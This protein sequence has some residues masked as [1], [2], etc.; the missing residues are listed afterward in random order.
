[1]LAVMAK[2]KNSSLHDLIWVTCVIFAIV[3]GSLIGLRGNVVDQH[4]SYKFPKF[5]IPHEQVRV[6]ILVYHYVEYVK[7]QKDTIRKSLS[8]APHV[9]EDQIKTLIADGY[10]FITFK[11]LNQY[12]DGRE[13]LPPKSII[14][15]F[16]DGYEDFYTDVFPILKKYKVPA[17]QYVISG[18]IDQPNYMKDR[19]L[20]EVIESGLVEIGA[21]TVDHRNLKHLSDL[22]AEWEISQSKKDLQEKYHILVDAFAYPYGGYNDHTP[23][24]VRKAGFS[25][26]VTT[27]G[28]FMLSNDSRFTLYRIHPGISIGY[29]LLSKF[30]SL[31]NGYNKQ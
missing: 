28:G 13:K 25:T 17:V 21:H 15:T 18:F 11:K 24:F 5:L 1:M 30:E 4:I 8:T 2:K 6:P 20:R 3:V 7:D 23:A 12:F 27:E 29:E 10:T 9:L 19:Q 14:L 16:D 22:D 31:T 26:A